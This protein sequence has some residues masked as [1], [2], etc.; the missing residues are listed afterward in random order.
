MKEQEEEKKE[1]GDVGYWEKKNKRCFPKLKQLYEDM[2]NQIKA[3][4]KLN[5]QIS[6]ND[7]DFF[8]LCY[9]LNEIGFS[10]YDSGPFFWNFIIYVFIVMNVFIFIL[11]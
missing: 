3:K 8:L 10:G 6:L 1:D 7:R 11:T 5:K 4:R 2:T 9:F